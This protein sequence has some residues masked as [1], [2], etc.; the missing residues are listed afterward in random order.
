MVNTLV[1]ILIFMVTG[2]TNLILFKEKFLVPIPKDPTNTT[3]TTYMTICLYSVYFCTLYLLVLCPLLC[4]RVL[5]HNIFHFPA[6]MNKVISGCVSLRV[7]I[8]WS[9]L[10]PPSDHGWNQRVWDL[11][12]MERN[13][14]ELQSSKFTWSR[15]P[16]LPLLMWWWKAGECIFG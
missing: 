11:Y 5:Y 4:P 15:T 3:H 14:L 10:D 9:N 16:M 1:I 8:R 13:K 7:T 6:G 2:G 12:E